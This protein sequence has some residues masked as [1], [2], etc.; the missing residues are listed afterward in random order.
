MRKLFTIALAGFCL[1]G[2]SYQPAQARDWNHDGRNHG[3]HDNGR[4]NGHDRW[5]PYNRVIYRPAPLVRYYGPSYFY[6]PYF[7]PAPYSSS[8]NFII[9]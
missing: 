3:W 7:Y 5:R 8:F 6:D 9:R 1:F 2:M 4:H